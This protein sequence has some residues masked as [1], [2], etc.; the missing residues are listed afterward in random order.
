MK[1]GKVILARYIVRAIAE[2]LQE[3]ICFFKQAS[4]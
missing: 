4:G 3:D 1:Q 2:Y